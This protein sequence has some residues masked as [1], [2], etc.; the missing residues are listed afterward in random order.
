MNVFENTDRILIVGGTGFIGRHLA[1]R[2]LKETPFVSCLSLGG[3]DKGPFLQ[4]IEII[5]DDISDKEQLHTALRGRK[6]DY[7]FNLGGYI[8]H[9]PYFKGGRKVIESHLIGLLNLLDCLDTK[10]LKGFVQIGSSDEYGNSPAP[11]KETMREHP[12]SP[13]SLAKTAAARFIQMLYHTED[14]PGTV[15]RF[16]LVYG[17]GQ[18]EKRFVPQIIRGCLKDEEFKASE[19]NQLRDF[20]YIDDVVDAMVRAAIFTSS[21]G[22][23]INI[24]S[25]IP[26][27]IKEMIQ[28]IMGLTGGGRPL[29]GAYPYRRG[30]SMELYADIS[31][32]KKL[33]GWDPVI[34][35]DEGLRKTI[36]YYRQF[37]GR[38]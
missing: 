27:S 8:D 31:L 15:L 7:V 36:E 21:K 35:L 22:H 24:A 20:C 10:C 33:L 34:P 28:K 38:K 1:E 13:Y 12:I 17:A 30:E 26:I 14:F 25:G 4:N 16:F 9:T 11:Q 19:G 5:K 37:E 6:F 2:C 23:V 32:A 3:H 18:D 29:W